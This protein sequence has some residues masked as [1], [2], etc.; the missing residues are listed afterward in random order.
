MFDVQNRW[1]GA[2]RAAPV[3]W[4]VSAA[5]ISGCFNASPSVKQAMTS[6]APVATQTTSSSSV[7]RGH[8]PDLASVAPSMPAVVA[9][10]RPKAA[11]F[12]LDKPA[13]RSSIATFQS[14]LHDFFD[15]ALARSAKY[16]PTMAGMLAHAGLPAE[17]AYLPL[18]ESGYRPQA[19]SPAG[20]VGPWQ[21]IPETGK[22]YG[23]RIDAMVDE[24]RDPIKST[25]AAAQYLK[26]LH[27]MFGDWELSLAAYNGGENRVA[28]ILADKGAQ[29]FWSMRDRGYLPSETSQYV[30]RFLA[31][32][33]IAKA[34]QVYG[35]VAPEDLPYHFETVN[36]DRQVSL[37][38]AAGLCGVSASEL[39][40]L[41]PALRRGI[42]PSGYALRVPTGAAAPL[43]TALASY[44]EPARATRQIART[45][46]GTA[47]GSIF[48]RRDQ[49]REVAAAL[50]RSVRT[51]GSRKAA[52][53]LVRE[54]A[55][56]ATVDRARREARPSVRVARACEPSPFAKARAKARARRRSG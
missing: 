17:L 10:M 1:G 32:V 21:F 24:R 27:E 23:L 49:R 54:A 53:P 38:T 50:V 48:A 52:R 42:T 46:R 29:N 14:E 16:V 4:L 34:P 43:R 40:D 30:P 5:L 55:R 33:S 26:D 13:V 41:N 8:I 44:V 3:A 22:K 6:G 45:S 31:A 25:E 12:D 7:A 51:F 15:G 35:F 2:G 9:A 18:I 56:A 11:S 37:S 36:V 39:A 19:V 47:R 20:A 28:R